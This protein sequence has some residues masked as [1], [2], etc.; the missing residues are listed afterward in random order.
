MMNAQPCN[1]ADDGFRPPSAGRY[2]VLRNVPLFSRLSSC[3]LA[4][5]AGQ[6]VT[7]IFARNT[8]IISEG[9]QTDSMYVILSGG[10]RVFLND[11]RGKEVT[12]AS[13][14]PYD[15][16][17]EIAP[18]DDSPRSASVITV[19]RS[20]FVI[21][22]K[23]DL[24]QC[25]DSDPALAI[26]IIKM[27]TLRVR[28]L[29]EKTRTF[30]LKDVYGRVSCALLEL[31]TEDGD[32]LVIPARPTQQDLANIV[33]ASREMVSRVLKELVAGGYLSVESRRIV[34]NK[35]LPGSY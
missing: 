34:I 5:L 22:A 14:G 15:Y 8:L 3:Q 12:L 2:R 20:S 16:F 33:G 24:K 9:D 19:D 7:K 18:L 29:N 31:A 6:A 23:S 21:I 32:K 25:V 28:S 13:L 4:T 35:P 1:R 10:V 30:A 26:D 17:G 11:A 27:L